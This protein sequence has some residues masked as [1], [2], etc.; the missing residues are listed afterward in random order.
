MAQP[1]DLETKSATASQR[2]EKDPDTRALEAAL[3]DVLGL[4]VSIDHKP[5]GGVLKISY[6]TLEQLDSVC[7]RLKH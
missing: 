5:N 1:A 4:K 3:E 2:A 7:R 6:R